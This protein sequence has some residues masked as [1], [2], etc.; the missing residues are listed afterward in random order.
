MSI[1]LTDPLQTVPVLVSYVD[2][3]LNRPASDLPSSKM[4]P[5]YLEMNIY[6]TQLTA[7][8]QVLHLLNSPYFQ[9][10]FTEDPAYLAGNKPVHVRFT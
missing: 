7:D 6:V 5:S 8:I 1:K 3:C 4:S 9:Q 10:L 2:P